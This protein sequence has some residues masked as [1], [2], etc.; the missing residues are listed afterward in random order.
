MQRICIGLHARHIHVILLLIE[1]LCT[2]LRV[3][4]VLL[5]HQLQKCLTEQLKFDTSEQFFRI[6]SVPGSMKS[7]SYVSFFT[8]ISKRL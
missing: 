5:Q 7:M 1:T 4:F 6:F 8:E 3:K 2:K